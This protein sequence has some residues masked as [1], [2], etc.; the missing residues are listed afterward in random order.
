MVRVYCIV[1]YIGRTIAPTVKGRRGPWRRPGERS[2]SSH[3]RRRRAFVYSPHEPF[4]PS[5]RAAVCPAPWPRAVR[6]LAGVALDRGARCAARH[7][8]ASPVCAAHARVLRDRRHR[9]RGI[10][11]SISR[12]H[13]ARAAGALVTISAG[14]MHTG[15]PDADC[16]WSYRMI[17]PQPGCF[18]SH[19]RNRS[20]RTSRCCFVTRS[21]TTA[22]CARRLTLC[23]DAL[24][25]A[26]VRSRSRGSGAA[27]PSAA[28]DASIRH[29]RRALPIT[30]ARAEVVRIAREYLDA[31]F[32][33][34]V[35]LSALA[36]VCGVSPFH[37][38]SRLSCS[39]WAFRR[40]RISSSCRVARAMAM[41]QRRRFRSR[42]SRTQCGFSDQSHLTRAFKA[43]YGFPPGAYRRAVRISGRNCCAT[44]LRS[45]T[46]RSAA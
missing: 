17:Y 20:A 37:L 30:A 27:L 38:D 16:G 46:R 18:A 32:A 12:M 2:C 7:A 19:S 44:R 11:R 42:A 22:T 26:G 4:V 43:T 21:S 34:R 1:L 29:V 15:G 33:E 31:H 28:V 35:H 36:E 25:A 13:R 6:R 9:R 39:A 41:L 40:T 8:A 14:E 24:S 23:T 45:C 3:T 10:A 5:D